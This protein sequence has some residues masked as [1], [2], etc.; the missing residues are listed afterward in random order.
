MRNRTCWD[1]RKK[2]ELSIKFLMMLI[3]AAAVVILIGVPILSKMYGIVMHKA[4]TGIANIMELMEQ[5]VNELK[6]G[7]NGADVVLY[8]TKKYSIV[9]FN[10]GGYPVYY[11]CNAFRKGVASVKPEIC[12]QSACLCVCESKNIN[13]EFPYDCRIFND[14]DN[15]YFDESGGNYKFEIGAQTDNRYR[16]LVIEITCGIFNTGIIDST[17]SESFHV[18]KRQENGKTNL[19]FSRIKK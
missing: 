10:K 8:L 16:Y 1:G 7:D 19:Y 4:P 15:I 17:I 14:I 6:P 11:N 3:L 12:G 13:C 5:T 2:G 18:E 9:G